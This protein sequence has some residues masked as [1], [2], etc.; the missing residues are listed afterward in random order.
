MRY[1]LT[2]IEG[3][4]TSVSFV[5]DTLFPFFKREIAVFLKNPTS[6]SPMLKEYL[7]EVQ[8]TAQ[9]EEGLSLSWEALA[10]TLIE[11]TEK[12]RKYA[13]FKAIQG[14]LW[15]SAYE[16]GMI[17]GHVYPDVAP[18]LARWREEGF[19]LGV[20]SSGSVAAQ[21]LLFKFSEVGDLTPF[22]DHYFD[23]AIGHKREP[24]SYCRIAEAIQIS[25]ADI[26]FLSDIEE[27]LDAAAKAGMLTTQ[28]VRPGTTAGKSHH[29]AADFSRV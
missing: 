24:Q 1:I 11:W 12:D 21:Q 10:P 27:E 7:L 22:F 4:T 18:A 5:Y 17:Q 29:I 23:T 19:Q 16:N 15:R 3:T 20:Y 9:R 28:L 2:D 25:P 6:L 26:L 8:L 13:P 14:L